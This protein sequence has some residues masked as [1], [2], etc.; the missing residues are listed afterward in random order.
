VAR[1]GSLRRVPRACYVS[2]L[3]PC[4]CFA[5]LLKKC[6][7]RTRLLGIYRSNGVRPNSVS[8]IFFCPQS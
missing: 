6:R 7:S 8:N 2:P 4:P 1:G 3:G 5:C